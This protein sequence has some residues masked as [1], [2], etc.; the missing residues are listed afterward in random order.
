MQQLDLSEELFTAAMKRFCNP[1]TKLLLKENAKKPVFGDDEKIKAN[2]GFTSNSI[3]NNLIPQ[4]VVKK[5]SA[6]AT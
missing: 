3:R 4:K 1:S 5:K 2:P 6:E